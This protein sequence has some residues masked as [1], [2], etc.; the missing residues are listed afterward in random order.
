M[1]RESPKEIPALIS[2]DHFTDRQPTENLPKIGSIFGKSSYK[3]AVNQLIR[4]AVRISKYGHF[5]IHCSVSSQS[6]GDLG[7]TL[8]RWP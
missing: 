1:C 8:I 7:Y 6:N 4:S 2:N 3:I 5:W